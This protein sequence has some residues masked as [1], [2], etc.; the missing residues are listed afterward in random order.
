MF[1]L[2]ASSL[3]PLTRQKL[4]AFRSSYRNYV[5]DYGKFTID[6]VVASSDPLD[7]HY[8]DYKGYPI[9]PFE[10]YKTGSYVTISADPVYIPPGTFVTIDGMNDPKGPI[11]FYNSV[12]CINCGQF[13]FI[14]VNNT[15]IYKTDT[16]IYQ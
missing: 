16:H 11:K 14:Y 15:Y 2:L 4:K 6:S 10:S 13:V 7:Y 9:R 8:Y 1:Y 3:K 12:P 5:K